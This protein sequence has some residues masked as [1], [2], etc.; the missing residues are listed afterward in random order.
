ML[1]K[2]IVYRL[3][4]PYGGWRLAQW[5]LGLG[6]L[7]LAIVFMLELVVPVRLDSDSAN[8]SPSTNEV[9]PNHVAEYLQPKPAS[10]QELARAMR[11]NLFKASTPLRDKP[12][13]D[14]T[15]ERI[16]SQLKLRCIMEID[17][18]PVAYINVKGVGLKKCKVGDCINDLFTV[19]RINQKTVETTI[20]GHRVTLRL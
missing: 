13:A 18:E 12:M 1:G 20:I 11:P 14:K 8:N 3:L 4:N 7:T 5:V 10:F 19:V 17:S 15:I 9:T 2:E 16:K 6:V